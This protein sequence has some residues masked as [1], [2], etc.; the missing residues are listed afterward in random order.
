MLFRITCSIITIVTSA[1][2]F[3]S[4]LYAAENRT[5]F[6]DPYQEYIHLR[7]NFYKDQQAY[8]SAVSQYKAYQ[9]AKSREDALDASKKLLESGRLTLKQ[10]LQLLSNTL[11]QQSDFNSRVKQSILSDLSVHNT[12]LDTVEQTIKDAQTISQ[13]TDLGKA[14][15][16]RITYIQ[17][18]ATQALGYIDAVTTKKQ[19]DEMLSIVYKFNNI[20]IGYPADNRSRNIVDKWIQETLPELANNESKLSEYVEALYPIPSSTK[21]TPIYETPGRI[22]NSRQLQDVASKQRNYASK[23]KEINQIIR[24]AYEEL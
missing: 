19:I 14:M 16:L 17:A 20:I 15:D 8:V 21:Q 1:T 24:S 23:L 9:T 12:Y 10:Y 11:N 4:T 6:P 5:P 22:S 18:T 7:N 3:L 2:L 13:I